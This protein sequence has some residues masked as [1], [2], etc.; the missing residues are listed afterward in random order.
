MRFLAAFDLEGA[1]VI[2]VGAC[3]GT[4]TLELSDLVGPQ[5]RVLAI[6]PGPEQLKFLRRNVA[7]NHLT[8]V[9]II[10]CA[11]GGVAETLHFEQ[12]PMNFGNGHLVRS[13]TGAAVSARPLDA[14]TADLP[15]DSIR[16]IKIDVEE[17][18]LEV[19]LGMR[20]TLRKNPAVIIQMEISAPRAT[21]VVALLEANALRGFQI[22]HDRIE[23]I[24]RPITELTNVFVT[25]DVEDLERRLRA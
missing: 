1:T 10:P 9:T 22:D 20:E 12:T 23:P 3:F 13:G 7:Q 18:E 4:Y 14:M 17:L 2:D 15:A 24:G 21:E 6:E 8:N 11:A 16:Y 25:R 5:G 19:L